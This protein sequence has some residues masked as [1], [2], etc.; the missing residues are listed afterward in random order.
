VLAPPRGVSRALLR[1]DEPQFWRDRPLL[2]P[3]LPPHERVL[4]AAD[5]AAPDEPI[6][7][8]DA[9]R[10]GAAPAARRRMRSSAFLDYV[11]C[12]GPFPSLRGRDL[13]RRFRSRGAAARF[14]ARAPF[15]RGGIFVTNACSPHTA[16]PA[17]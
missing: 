6:E 11:P 10:N 15:A 14:P 2:P 17:A 7:V 16:S 13:E 4:P 5:R 12:H 9:E 3:S 1:P 8:V